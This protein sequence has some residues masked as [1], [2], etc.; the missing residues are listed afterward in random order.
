MSSTRFRKKPVVIEA[1]SAAE[2]LAAASAGGFSAKS[3]TVPEWIVQAFE[4]AVLGFEGSDG[5]EFVL[6]RTPEGVMKAA[7]SDWIIQGVK[8]ELYPCKPDIFQQT[9]DLADAP[10]ESRAHGELTLLPKWEASARAMAEWVFA[11]YRED[12]SAIEAGKPEP[13]QLDFIPKPVVDAAMWVLNKNEREPS[14]Q[15]P[16][17]ATP[18]EVARERLQIGIRAIV[19]LAEHCGDSAVRMRAAEQLIETYYPLV[20]AEQGAPDVPAQ[21]KKPQP[22]LRERIMEAFR[23]RA[24]LGFD[25]I[26]ILAGDNAAI[27]A[28]VEKM[29]AEG[30][31]EHAPGH[32]PGHFRP[33]YRGRPDPIATQLPGRGEAVK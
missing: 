18:L 28:E 33:V 9:Y 16:R 32:A 2:V 27:I 10:R 14:E 20:A 6:I 5:K 13:I 23:Q 22:E 24:P 21:P 15:E 8:G 29:A 11:L 1:I 17:Q 25:E 26:I 19:D 3:R 30:V 31:I 4:Q 12:T 7:P